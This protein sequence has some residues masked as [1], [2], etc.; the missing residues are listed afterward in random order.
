V[1]ASLTRLV[2][3][4]D[5]FLEPESKQRMLSD[6]DWAASI[7]LGGEARHLLTIGRS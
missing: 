3:E 5:V 2:L 1:D 7:T 6:A 4:P